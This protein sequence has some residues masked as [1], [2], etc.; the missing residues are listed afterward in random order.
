MKDILSDELQTRLRQNEPLNL[1]DVREPL[2]FYSYNIGGTL[3]PLGKLSEKSGQLPWNKDAEIIVICKLGL[4][5]QTAKVILEHLGY[6][7]VRNLIGGLM[8]LKKID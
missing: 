5:S 4:R 1:L 8:A 3:V 7:K 2:E 6:T